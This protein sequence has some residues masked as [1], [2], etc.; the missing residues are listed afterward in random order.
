[1]P[2]YP[3][4]PTTGGKPTAKPNK[5][6]G[7]VPSSAAIQANRE[8]QV[9]DYIRGQ[10]ATAAM[11][12]ERFAPQWGVPPSVVH[13]VRREVYRQLQGE[14]DEECMYA[15]ERQREGLSRL[16]GEANAVGDIGE[17]RK[18]LDQL[19]KVE[20]AYKAD[21]MTLT[22]DIAIGPANPDA[23]RAR[24]AEL[25]A[26][27]EIQAAMRATQAPVPTP[28]PTPGSP[29]PDGNNPSVAG[30]NNAK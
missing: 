15:R 11:V 3:K 24:M 12:A 2:K 23:T 28:T 21:A 16:I 7:R 20:G 5:A 22:G 10:A 19:A 25:L 30:Q 8:A 26:D 14:A 17:A 29:T 6:P 4:N 9:R 1:M 18:C 13:A 27:P